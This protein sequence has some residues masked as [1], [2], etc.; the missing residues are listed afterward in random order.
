MTQEQII[1]R[2]RQE[3]DKVYEKYENEPFVDD[4]TEGFEDI[5]NEYYEITKP[6]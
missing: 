1:H 6:Y 4:I 2:I 3:L 5:I